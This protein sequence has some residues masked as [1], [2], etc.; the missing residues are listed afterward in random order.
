MKAILLFWFAVLCIWELISWW[1]NRRHQREAL[2]RW[3]RLQR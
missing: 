2:E 3:E 1:L